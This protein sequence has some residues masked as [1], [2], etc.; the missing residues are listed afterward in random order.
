MVK[1]ETQKEK[2]LRWV[3]EHAQ[4]STEPCYI[5]TG[6]YKPFMPSTVNALVKDGMVTITAGGTRRWG[7]VRLALTEAGKN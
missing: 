6:K 1:P 7:Y 4:H 5:E 2:L 3:R